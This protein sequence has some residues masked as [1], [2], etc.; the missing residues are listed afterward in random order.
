MSGRR[1][2]T[3]ERRAGRLA[4]GRRLEAAAREREGASRCQ[5]TSSA[6]EQRPRPGSGSIALGLAPA[7]PGALTRP[8]CKACRKLRDPPAAAAARL[9]ASAGGPGTPGHCRCGKTRPVSAPAALRPHVFRGRASEPPVLNPRPPSLFRARARSWKKEPNGPL[10]S[11]V[12]GTRGKVSPAPASSPGRVVAPSS[13]DCVCS[14]LPLSV[15]NIHAAL[16]V[17]SSQ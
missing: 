9:P 16:S 8:S 3:G 4:P 13:A 14:C 10:A 1:P 2:S 15:S 11:Q 17:L 12:L 5:G 6:R 7:G